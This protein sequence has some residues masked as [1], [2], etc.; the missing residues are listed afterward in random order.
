MDIYFIITEAAVN[1]VII[2]SDLERTSV[3]FN[4]GNETACTPRE[5]TQSFTFV[6]VTIVECK[7]HRHYNQSVQIFYS[8]NS[9]T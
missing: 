5:T 8:S 2:K 1:I 3:N 7:S 6:N 4:I 9:S